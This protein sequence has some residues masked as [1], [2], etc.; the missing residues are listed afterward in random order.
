AVLPRADDRTVRELEVLDPT[1]DHIAER[2]ARAVLGIRLDAH[3]PAVRIE[4]RLAD[5]NVVGAGIDYPGDALAVPI[6]HEEHVLTVGVVR[7]PSAEPRALQRMPF[8]GACRHPLR[9]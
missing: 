3:H 9:E 1:L 8:L 4:R 7:F 2:P 5:P 6:E